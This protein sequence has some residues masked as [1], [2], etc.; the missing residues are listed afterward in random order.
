MDCFDQTN[1]PKKSVLFFLIKPKRSHG[2][3]N[4]WEKGKQK[5]LTFP[6]SDWAC[7][8]LT[9]KQCSQEEQTT[10]QI[11][12]QAGDEHSTQQK[13]AKYMDDEFKKEEEDKKKAS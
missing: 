3:K 12:A 10:T 4:R 13:S 6:L 1:E 8:P 5:S 2:R 9:S 7:L 11:L